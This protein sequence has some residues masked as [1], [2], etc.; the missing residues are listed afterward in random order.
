M[1]P[2]LD[3]KKFTT[4]SLNDVTEIAN[5]LDSALLVYHKIPWCTN[6]TPDLIAKHDESMGRWGN[7][8]GE[9]RAIIEQTRKD[10]DYLLGGVQLRKVSHED[11]VFKM[12]EY[13]QRYMEYIEYISLTILPEVNISIMGKL[14][15]YSG[16]GV[17]IPSTPE[18]DA[19]LNG[20]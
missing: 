2:F 12:I 17:A 1:S 11:A 8:L 19:I 10:Y 7:V 3:A 9:L 20:N 4:S 14:N 16:T 13:T 6:I 18:L 15:S 5:K